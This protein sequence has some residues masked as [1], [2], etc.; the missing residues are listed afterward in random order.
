MRLFKIVAHILFNTLVSSIA[1]S[2]M[3][4]SE[5]YDYVRD[6]LT[7]EG[8]STIFILIAG[9]VMTTIFPGL[10]FIQNLA[11]MMSLKALQ[12]GCSMFYHKKETSC[13]TFNLKSKLENL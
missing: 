1:I 13:L 3:V 5:K 7:E 12:K 6:Y 2:V 4:K 9:V 10:L 8:S 11:A